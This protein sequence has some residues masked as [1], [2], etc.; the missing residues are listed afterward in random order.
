M[1]APTRY[2]VQAA[3]EMGGVI[4]STDN[5]RDLL[6]ENPAWKDTIE[7]RLLMFTWVEDILM[8]PQDPLGR[9][10][11]TLEEFL[12]FPIYQDQDLFMWPHGLRRNLRI[13]LGCQRQ[14]NRGLRNGQLADG[15]VSGLARL[16]QV[17]AVDPGGPN[18]DAS[19]SGGFCNVT[20]PC[21]ADV[22]L[23]ETAFLGVGLLATTTVQVGRDRFT[24]APIIVGVGLGVVEFR[25][26]VGDGFPALLLNS[27]GFTD[28]VKSGGRVPGIFGVGPHEKRCRAPPTVIVPRVARAASR[29]GVDYLPALDCAGSGVVPGEAR[30]ARVGVTLELVVIARGGVFIVLHGS[31]TYQEVFPRGVGLARLVLHLERDGAVVGEVQ[32]HGHRRLRAVRAQPP[33]A[34]CNE[35]LLGFILFLWRRLGRAPLVSGGRRDR[36]E[37][38]GPVLRRQVRRRRALVHTRRYLYA[39]PFLRRGRL[40]RRLTVLQSPGKLNEGRSEGASLV[41][42]RPLSERWDGCLAETGLAFWCWLLLNLNLA[43]TTLAALSRASKVITQDATTMKPGTVTCL[44]RDNPHNYESM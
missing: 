21:R 32:V 6:E 1:C 29:P 34:G 16:L 14:G 22:Q 31:L 38:R 17:R 42:R 7:K 5:F 4:V 35:F 8:F 36:P 43:G 10:G 23:P 28:Y 33:P 3:H 25:R 20:S 39:Q 26:P 41:L 13:R 37:G 44:V 19:T 11:P 2:I 18:M 30:T 9:N 15:G 40:R 27:L 24:S 12:R